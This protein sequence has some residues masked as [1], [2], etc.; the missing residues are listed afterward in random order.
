MSEDQ[1]LY[2][3]GKEKKVKMY[4][5][6]ITYQY[7]DEKGSIGNGY[8]GIEYEKKIEYMSDINR[9]ISGLIE[10]KKFKNVVITSWTLLKGLDR[11]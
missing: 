5:Y 3:T 9:L 4:T 2:K 10:S 7:K 8:T 1:Q 6:Y 11:P